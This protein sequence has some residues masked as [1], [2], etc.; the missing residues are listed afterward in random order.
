MSVLNSSFSC[1]YLD[2]AVKDAK[3][4]K[5]SVAVP[6]LLRG[7]EGCLRLTVDGHSEVSVHAVPW[8]GLASGQ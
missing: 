1:P 2:T 6:E 3:K 4:S 7:A 8:S 5:V